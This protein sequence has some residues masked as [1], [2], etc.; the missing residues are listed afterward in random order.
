M[1]NFYGL[2]DRIDHVLSPDDGILG[3]V[4]FYVSGKQQRSLHA[5]AIGG[6][7]KEC[8]WMARWFWQIWFDFDHV[9]LSPLRR[10]YLEYKF[11]TVSSPE[12]QFFTN[13][14][15]FNSLRAIMAGIDLLFLSLSACMSLFTDLGT[16]DL[17]SF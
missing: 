11:G 15:T 1:P 7:S 4:D 14:I 9:S 12:N 2:L 13:L 10:D 8:G 6:V 16:Q 5:K 17:H 3:V